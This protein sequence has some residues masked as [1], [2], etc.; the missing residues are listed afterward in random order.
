M[1]PRLF[2]FDLDGTLV[3]SKAP[4]DSEMAELFSHL[5]EKMPVAVISGAG[6]PQFEEQLLLP[7]RPYHPSFDRLSLFPTTGSAM[8]VC[9]DGASWTEVYRDVLSSEDKE[10][11]SSALHD[12]EGAIGYSDPSPVYGAV[13]ED[14]GSQET[15]SAL[16]NDV[17]KDL[18][19]AA[20][21][22]LKRKWHEESDRRPELVSELRKQLPDFE[23]RMGGL[24][25]IDITPKGRDKAYGVRK[26]LEAFR[27]SPADA[28]F[29]GDALGPEGN[30]A[31]AQETGVRIHAVS[32]P[33]DTK[34]LI[35]SFL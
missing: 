35:R 16:G 5:L 32:G 34:N 17:V 2:I 10:R 28:L 19:V 11:I 15:F 22:S 4:M 6:F 31:P 24:T 13:L 14:R 18:G 7:L 29:V 9:K 8:Y 21:V 12:A 26:I 1:I 30:D 20:G 33:E 3:E 27:I 25:S 23:I